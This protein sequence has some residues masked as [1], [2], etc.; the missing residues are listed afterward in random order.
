MVKEQTTLARLVRRVKPQLAEAQQRTHYRTCNDRHVAPGSV[1]TRWVERNSHLSRGEAEGE[2]TLT[3]AT[4]NMADSVAYM[5]REQ[6]LK[7]TLRKRSH[8]THCANDVWEQ[9]K[10]GSTCLTATPSAKLSTFASSTRR[11]CARLMAIAL[12]PAHPPAHS[13]NQSRQPRRPIRAVQPP[14]QMCG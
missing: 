1:P 2:Q 7:Q 14:P 10:E 13:C 9:Q 12:A 5:V 8:A 3:T 4:P 11:P 6:H